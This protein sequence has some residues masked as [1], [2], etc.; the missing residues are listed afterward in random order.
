MEAKIQSSDIKIERL[1]KEDLHYI[2][3]F[4]CGNEQ[5]DAFFI[6]DVIKCIDSHYVVAYCAKLKNDNKIVAIFTLANDAIILTN[7]SDSDDFKE[8]N[9]NLFSEEYQAIFK[10]QSSYPAIN[11]AH[12]AVE[13]QYQGKGIGSHIIDYLIDTFL[14][15][16]IAGCQLITVDSLN[17]P[18][19]NKFYLKNGFSNFT[20]S[21]SQSLTRRMYL[22]LEAYRNL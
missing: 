22:L 18:Q 5:L 8:E 1:E 15:Y 6:Q 4:S 13:N 16:K 3:N 17:N 14:E 11:I 7:N 19:T 10:E 9:Y 12:L 20:N 21:D 2:K